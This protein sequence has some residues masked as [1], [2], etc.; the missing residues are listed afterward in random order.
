MALE[1]AV[2]RWDVE[3]AVREPA[4]VPPDLAVDGVD[5]I[6]EI[7]IPRSIDLA[8]LDAE[9]ATFH[10]HATD[11]EGEWLVHLAADGITF[12]HGHAKGDVALRGTASD[13]YL[14]CWNRVPVD[15][16]FEVFGDAG[17]LDVWRTAVVI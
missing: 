2:H 17:L 7:Q 4:A 5:E 9:G 12:E 10:L 15:D 6:L 13:L 11:A 14:W 1:T 16:R 3:G 8:T